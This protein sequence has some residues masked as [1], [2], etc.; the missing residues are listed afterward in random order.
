MQWLP[1]LIVGIAT[2]IYAGVCAGE[3]AYQ[4]ARNYD[5]SHLWQARQRGTAVVG[6]TLL[7]YAAPLQDFAHWWNY[8]AP[9]AALGAALC[10][11]GFLFDLWLN[12]RR[13]LVWYYSGTDPNT[14]KADRLVA[15]LKIDGPLYPAL[16]IGGVFFFIGAALWLS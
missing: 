16:K 8:L 3:D 7:A 9:L 12:E 10:W 6:F 5:V 15:K 14:A 2:G 11:F 13:R 4:I 1:L